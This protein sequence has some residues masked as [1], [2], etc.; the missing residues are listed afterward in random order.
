MNKCKTRQKEIYKW[1]TSH[2]SGII[3]SYNVTDWFQA[4]LVSLA[5]GLSTA[6]RRLGYTFKQYT[7]NINEILWTL[8]SRT[9]QDHCL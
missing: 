1:L 2:Y 7:L 9:L 3:L 5:V 8:E 6:L 4:V